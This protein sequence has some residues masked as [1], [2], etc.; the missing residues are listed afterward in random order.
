MT[1]L[2]Q[3]Q[4]PEVILASFAVALRSA[5]VPVTMDRTQ[6]FLTAVAAVG[7]DDQSGVYWAGRAT[8]CGCL[9]D[10]DR[11]DHLFLAW[12]GGQGLAPGKPRDS[13]RCLDLR[14]C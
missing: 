4:S 13:L 6:T 2:R 14:C 5:G 7:V 10:L 9:D 3:A 12:F 8:L 11:Y 1:E